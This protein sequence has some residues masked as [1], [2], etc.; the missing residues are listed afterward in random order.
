MNY[1]IG[2]LCGD[3]LSWAQAC[4]SGACLNSLILKQFIQKFEQIFDNPNHAG[5]ASDRLFYLRHGDS[6]DSSNFS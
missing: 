4:S 3:A 2:L 5:T 1:I 6:L